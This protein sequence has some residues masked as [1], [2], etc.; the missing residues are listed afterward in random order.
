VLILDPNQCSL[1]AFGD[2]EGCTRMAARRID[3]TVVQ[4]RLADPAHLGRRFFKVQGS[5]LPE[6]TFILQGTFQRCYLKL[7]RQLVPLHARCQVT[8]P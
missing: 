8:P 5:D 4:Q 2:C 1:N 7:D 3:V 6:L